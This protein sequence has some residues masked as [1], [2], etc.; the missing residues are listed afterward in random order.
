VKEP[1]FQKKI[2][3][4]FIIRI[5]SYELETP[6]TDYKLSSIKQKKEGKKY[7]DFLNLSEVQ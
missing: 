3:V 7:S 1:S 5:T 6:T 2:V 4:T